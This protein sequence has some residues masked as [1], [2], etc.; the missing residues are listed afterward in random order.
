MQHNIS[1]Y[2]F[3]YYF[4]LSRGI[5]LLLFGAMR[6]FFFLFLPVMYYLVIIPQVYIHG[7]VCVALLFFLS[8]LV[9]YIYSI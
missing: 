1:S 7:T 4:F 5:F 9:G 6:F 8:L 3:I 2:L